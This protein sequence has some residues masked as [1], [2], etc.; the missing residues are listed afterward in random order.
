[1]R[2]P[3][4]QSPLKTQSAQENMVYTDKQQVYDP[5]GF[6]ALAAAYARRIFCSLGLL[7]GTIPAPVVV[8]A[9]L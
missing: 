9:F 8:L 6:I 4:S 7:F 5:P 2:E 1:M 3:N